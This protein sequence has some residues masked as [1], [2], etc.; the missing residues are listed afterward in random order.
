MVREKKMSTKEW[1]KEYSK[2]LGYKFVDKGNKKHYA[3]VDRKGKATMYNT[4]EEAKND[5]L[6]A[7]HNYIG[8]HT[9]IVDAHGKVLEMS[10]ADKRKLE[11]KKRR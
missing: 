3:L 1:L 7:L 10:P 9:T 8:D 2:D 5:L 6:R 4:L 11:A